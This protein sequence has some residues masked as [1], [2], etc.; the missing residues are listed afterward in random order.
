MGFNPVLGDGTAGPRGRLT[1]VL[2]GWL[3]VSISRTLKSQP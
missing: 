2:N 3:G 1:R